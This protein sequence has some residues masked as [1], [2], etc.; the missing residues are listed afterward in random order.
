MM[1]SFD[2]ATNRDKV[3]Q[4]AGAV[5]GG[6]SLDNINASSASACSGLATAEP[7]CPSGCQS[8]RSSPRSDHG[9]TAHTAQRYTR[10]Q[11]PVGS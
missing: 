6:T 7:I 4:G 8:S 5:G 3:I 9:Y 1:E 10:V 2:A 11:H